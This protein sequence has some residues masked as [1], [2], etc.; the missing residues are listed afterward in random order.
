MNE[1]VRSSIEKC[2][3]P[4]DALDEFMPPQRAAP[5]LPASSFMAHNIGSGSSPVDGALC[6]IEEGTGTTASSLA[7][8]KDLL[9]AAFEDQQRRQASAPLDV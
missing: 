1:F 9:S 4:R 5:Q 7:T 2:D 8:F 3:P 6:A